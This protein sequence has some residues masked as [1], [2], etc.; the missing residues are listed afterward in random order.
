MFLK[1]AA[2]RLYLLWCR[3][4]GQQGIQKLVHVLQEEMKPHRFIRNVR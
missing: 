1:P 2:V 4:A 3:L